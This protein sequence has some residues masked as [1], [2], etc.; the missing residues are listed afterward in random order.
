VRI[1]RHLAVLAAAS[2]GAA[3]ASPQRP[4]APPPTIRI[5]VQPAPAG[6]GTPF[7]KCLACH[8]AERG[9]AD[10][11]GPNLFGVFGRRAGRRGG[12][13]YSE[14]MRRSGLTW[15]AATLDRFLT[16]PSEAVPGTKMTFPGLRKPEDRQA[17]IAFLKQRF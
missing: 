2:C 1:A 9:G 16:S 8:N 6:A 7:A 12:Y 11:L 14:A 3:A 10:G 13:P 5:V 4:Q 17:A 15:D